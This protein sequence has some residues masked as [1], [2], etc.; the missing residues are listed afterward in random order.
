VLSG[1]RS[2]TRDHQVGDLLG[3][4]AHVA[5]RYGVAR[6]EHRA[7]VQGP[8]GCVPIEAGPG[9][10]TFHDLRHRD[11]ELLQ[12][13][14]GHGGILDEGDRLLAFGAAEQQRQ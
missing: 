10:V 9:A 5:K 2:P 11:H 1:D 3:D 14:G 13:L 4:L 6:V 7:H 8:H 12:A